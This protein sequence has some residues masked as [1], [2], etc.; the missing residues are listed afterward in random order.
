MCRWQWG[1]GL[2]SNKFNIMTVS[3]CHG[4]GFFRKT[5]YGAVETITAVRCATNLPFESSQFTLNIRHDTWS[6][7]TTIHDPPWR[8]F[9]KIREQISVFKN[10]L[11]VC[12]GNAYCICCL[13]FPH[14]IDGLANISILP[15]QYPSVKFHIVI[16]HRTQNL[17]FLI[18][19]FHFHTYDTETVGFN[20][21]R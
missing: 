20:V 13:K 5:S 16:V 11:S 10:I 19:V 9:P 4:V 15:I 1:C 14:V 8:W 7:I 21:R 12:V 3:I 6:V 2:I 17:I 18:L